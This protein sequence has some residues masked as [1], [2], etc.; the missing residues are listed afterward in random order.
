MG[1][2]TALADDPIPTTNVVAEEKAVQEGDFWTRRYE[3]AV[4]P[5]V[6]GDSD[7]GLELGAAA[8]LSFFGDGVVPYRWNMDLVVA[9][10]P[11]R[12]LVASSSRSNRTSGTSTS[13]RSQ[14]ASCA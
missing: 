12:G 7:I 8:T 14:A 13:P 3:P 10:S 5:I 9:A 6:A 4:L 1:G 11:R 2:R